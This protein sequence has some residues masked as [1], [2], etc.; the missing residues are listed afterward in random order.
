M[1][2]NVT[3]D[4]E[5]G[6]AKGLAGAIPRPGGVRPTTPLFRIWKEGICN[7]TREWFM[8]VARPEARRGL[9]AGLKPFNAFPTCICF[10]SA[11]FF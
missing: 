2:D 11:F 5:S 10:G 8:T 1:L 4:S 7:K 9:V 3:K 6:S